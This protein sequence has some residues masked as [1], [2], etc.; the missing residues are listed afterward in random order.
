MEPLVVGDDED[1]GQD[2][3]HDHRAAHQPDHP[4]VAL[5]E[6]DEAEELPHKGLLQ[7]LPVL[8]KVVLLVHDGRERCH[9]DA[10]KGVEEQRE[11]HLIARLLLK[12]HCAQRLHPLECLLVLL[13]D[14]CDT[15]KRLETAIII[16]KALVVVSTS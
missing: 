1:G 12:L 3:H 11:H 13:Q 7:V 9:G 14:P 15:P 10:L 16:L 4:V 5:D 8:V 6:G 2:D